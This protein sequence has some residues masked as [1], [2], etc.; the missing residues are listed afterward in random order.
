MSS[1][2]EKV[3]VANRGEIACR[4]LRALRE[5]GLRSVAVYSEADAAAPHVRLADEAVPIGPAPARESYLRIDRIVEAALARKAGAVHPGYGFLSENPDF[6]AACEAAGLVFLGPPAETIALM[7]RKARA[8]EVMR[9]VGVPVL[10]GSPELREVADAERAADALGFPVILKATAGGGGIGMQVARDA[11]DLRKL[12]P[13]AKSRAAA[14]FRDDAIYLERFLERPRHVEVQVLGDGRG[15]VAHLFERECSIQRRHQKVVEESPAP[16]LAA[17]ADLRARLLDAAVR[18]AAHVRYRNA[19][20]LE[21][22]FDEASGEFFFMEMNTRLQ[23]EHPVTEMTTGVDLVRAQLEVA[24]RGELPL[25]QADL[26]QRGHAIEVRVY[27][28]DPAKGFAPQ[29][30]K[31]G[32]VVWPSGD[33]V[34]CDAG[35]EAGQAVTPFYDPLLA[36]IVA[37]GATR[38]EA[39]GR[40]RLALERAVVA[41]VRTNLAMLRRLAADPPFERGELDTGFLSRRKDLLA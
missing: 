6:A 14:V 3:L 39:L 20:T 30:G 38:G 22:L 40:L 8:R 31:L 32:E 27:A 41:G 1:R 13:Q 9:E 29:P 35:Y 15:G 10:P 2:F 17:R 23:V 21:F 26:V 24:A 11:A 28:E 4:V 37:H 25:A 16:A 5:A 19:G 12:F 7:G 36:K 33:G 34:R 18:G